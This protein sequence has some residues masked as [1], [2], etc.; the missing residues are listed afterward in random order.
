MTRPRL[1]GLDALRFL[2]VLLVLGRHMPE[3]PADTERVLR[4]F[5]ETWRR[6]GW[7][8]VDL[9]FVLS[10][11]L[12]SGLLFS[13]EKA[14]QGFSIS[15]FYVRR[16]W[17]IYPPFLF[18]LAVSVPGRL[19][20][21]SGRVPLKAMATELFFLQSYLP[22]LWVHTWSL[23]VEEHFYLLLPLVLTLVRRR[24]RDPDKPFEAV[25]PLALALGVV[26]LGLR[27]MVWYTSPAYSVRSY[28]QSHLRMDALF[29][30]VMLSY[31]KHFHGP[32]FA[33]LLGPFRHGLIALGLLCV[34]PAFLFEQSDLLCTFG[35]TLFSVGCGL[36]LVGVFLSDLSQS[37]VARAMAG[38]GQRS[39]SVYLWHI[40]VAALV[41]NFAS[42]ILS[43][44]ARVLA[45]VLVSFAVGAL[46]ATL[47]EAPALRLRDRWFPSLAA[48]RGL[49]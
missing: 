36:V 10:G 47:I 38:L 22:G 12:V 24:D 49:R 35:L 18:L 2:A 48:G 34:S 17:K 7:I 25:F 28:F 9:F 29:L 15:R 43:Y 8:G 14:R 30:G 32:R 6:G 31:L 26:C 3:P 19:I 39:Y 44:P 42:R 45:Y 5:L 21:G 41:E 4:L 11:F 16:A 40:P 33:S 46:M 13:E 23:A 1:V 37:R 20:L 27:L